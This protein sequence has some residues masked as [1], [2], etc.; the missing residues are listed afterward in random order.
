[1][2]GGNVFASCEMKGAS[3]L[4][5]S[6]FLLRE[7]RYG[8]GRGSEGPEKNRKQLCASRGW[9]LAMMLLFHKMAFN[10]L[11]ELFQQ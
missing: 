6:V 10:V 8:C 1:M 9:G 7:H 2:K 5:V 11:K 4:V 3:G